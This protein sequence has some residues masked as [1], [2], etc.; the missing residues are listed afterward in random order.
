[1]ASHWL[2]QPNQVGC[3]Q[4][5]STYIRQDL[6]TCN[7]DLLD[8][9]NKAVSTAQVRA[10]IEAV[11]DATN[12]HSD[13]TNILDADCDLDQDCVASISY[14]TVC[15]GMLCD[16]RVEILVSLQSL[17]ECQALCW[18]GSAALRHPTD[19]FQV[20]KLPS[21]TAQ[22]LQTLSSEVCSE[23]QFWLSPRQQLSQE[24]DRESD[25]SA[26]AGAVPTDRR[27][28]IIIYGPNNMA[29]RVGEWLDGI[30]MYLQ[31]PGG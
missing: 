7:I 2:H 20:V 31:I 4:H 30:K 25:V 12:F 23:F 1:V 21:I 5:A 9:A 10:S 8:S 3:V 22:V 27:L 13:P 26:S 24:Q 11:V 14:I 15:Y 16:I 29:T 19:G 17:M 18:D 28:S 6:H